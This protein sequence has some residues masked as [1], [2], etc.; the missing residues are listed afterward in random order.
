MRTSAYFLLLAASFW[1]TKPPREWSGQEL[2]K[3]TEDSPWAQIVSTAR[4][5]TAPGVQVYLA[6]ATPVRAAE[7][8][9][10]RRQKSPPDLLREEYEQFLRED[11]GRSVVL[12]VYI[13]DPQ[14][15]ADAA[16]SR[17][18][19]QECL[20]K[21]GRQEV[22]I[23]GHFPPST[24]DPFL[25]LVFPRQDTGKAKALVFV[26]YLPSVPSP[27]RQVEFN[28]KDLQYRGKTDY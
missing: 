11:E 26:L 12:A 23:T 10:A 20:M 2:R 1:E 18:M 3:I 7:A 16:E 17:R 24:T 13:P 22:R 28:L 25:R 27:Y 15:L 19:E 6:T 4:A 8:E 21:V 5:G 9:F 14:A